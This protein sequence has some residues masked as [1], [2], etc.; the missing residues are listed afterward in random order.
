MGGKEDYEEK[1]HLYDI[2]TGIAVKAR[3]IEECEHHPD[4]YIDLDDDEAKSRAYAIGS[5]M[6]KRGDINVERKQLMDAIKR[7]IDDAGPECYSCK[8][9]EEE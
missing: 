7:V 1:E 5:N 4:T 3:A 6:I 2:A 9:W 8:K